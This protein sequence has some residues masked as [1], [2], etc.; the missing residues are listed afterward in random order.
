MR[1]G[2]KRFYENEDGL[3]DNYLTY[4]EKVGQKF[5]GND[6]VIGF[7]LLNEPWPAS[8]GE[9]EEFDTTLFS[10][11]ETIGETI[12]QI[13][14]DKILFFQPSAFPGVVPNKEVRNTRFGSNPLEERNALSSVLS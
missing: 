14:S 4:W 2:F 9:S 5:K 12:R 8:I 7:D 13:D 6:N 1:D 11:Y 10:L 3:F